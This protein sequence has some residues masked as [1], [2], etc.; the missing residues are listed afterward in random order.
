MHV[1]H[2]TL[3]HTSR[4]QIQ[5]HKCTHHT[6]HTANLIQIKSHTCTC[7]TRHTYTSL[8]QIKSNTCTCLHTPAL[9][10]PH[11]CMQHACVYDVFV[12][13]IFLYF[14]YLDLRFAYLSPF[15]VLR[16]L[17]RI[18]YL[19]IAYTSPSRFPKDS[20]IFMS[21]VGYFFHLLLSWYKYY[22]ILRSLYLP[23][24]CQHIQSDWFDMCFIHDVLILCRSIY[25]AL[26]YSDTSPLGLP[27]D[28]FASASACAA[29]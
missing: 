18:Q 15:C 8:I 7:L 25:S 24:V 21:Y 20:K 23:T 27:K 1:S 6:T 28:T 17:F 10:P 22:L 16:L 3:H 14:L 2:N 29:W 11:K 13:Y 9:V 5:S 26:M 4:T 12:F 19:C